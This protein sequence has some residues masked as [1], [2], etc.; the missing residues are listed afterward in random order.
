MCLME[1]VVLRFNTTEAFCR[2]VERVLRRYGKY[3]LRGEILT[4]KHLT[5]TNWTEFWEAIDYYAIVE[6]DRVV[7]LKTDFEYITGF[8]IVEITDCGIRP[9]GRVINLEEELKKL[10][11]GN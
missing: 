8:I 3:M 1:S 2:A 4:P 11:E 10:E 5:F 7:Q 9:K 6:N